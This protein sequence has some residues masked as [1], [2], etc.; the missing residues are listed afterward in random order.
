MSNYFNMKIKKNKVISTIRT[1]GIWGIILF[2]IAIITIAFSYYTNGMSIII[3]LLII[4]AIIILLL[5]IGVFLKN[6]FSAY[7]LCTFFIIDTTL[8][9]IGGVM[10]LFIGENSGL[11]SLFFRFIVLPYFLRGAKATMIYN[12]HFK[13]K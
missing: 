2:L 10:G 5:T 6:T 3:I 1:L 4:W 9:F 12:K 7:M 8:V 13:K 11:S